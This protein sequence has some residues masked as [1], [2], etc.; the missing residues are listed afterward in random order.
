MRSA[1]GYLARLTEAGRPGDAAALR[2][3]RPLFAPDGGPPLVAG[4]GGEARPPRLTPAAPARSEDGAT[5]ASRHDEPAA[6]D[7]SRLWPARGPVPQ[8]ATG[9]RT[10]GAAGPPAAEP[11]IFPGSAGRAGPPPSRAGADRQPAADETDAALE[12]PSRPARDPGPGRQQPVRRAAVVPA[13]TPSPDQGSASAP[14]AAGLAARRGQPGPEPGKSAREEGAS[15]SQRPARGLP[16]SPAHGSAQGLS[17]GWPPGRASAPAVRPG[18]IPELTP[19]RRPQ[20]A[21]DGNSGAA[22]S[23]QPAAPARHGAAPARVTIGTIEVTVVPP[24]PPPP[25]PPASHAPART[26][27]P[28]RPRGDAVRHGARRWFGTGQI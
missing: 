7:A 17:H 19:S 14:A 16:A 23:G 5:I 25:S 28:Q 3:P 6:F 15:A 13:A 27:G 8:V 21:R 24:A 18:P 20:S 2:P 4:A 1:P 12:R 10:G 9:V 26:A 11:V 22:V